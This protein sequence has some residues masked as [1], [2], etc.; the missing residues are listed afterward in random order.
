MLDPLCGTRGSTEHTFPNTSTSILPNDMLSLCRI[1]LKSNFLNTKCGSG[2]YSSSQ[3]TVPHPCHYNVT[4][5][6]YGLEDSCDGKTWDKYGYV[7]ICRLPHVAFQ[8]ILR[9]RIMLSAAWVFY[10]LL[11]PRARLDRFPL[12]AFLAITA[13]PEAPDVRCFHFNLTHFSPFQIPAKRNM[14]GPSACYPA[15]LAVPFA[16]SPSLSQPTLKQPTPRPPMVRFS[17]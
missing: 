2:G 14:A 3:L 9:D 8:G 12:L 4:Q 10:A 5:S 17:I 6:I 1:A 11:A 15:K 16:A 13:A 7:D